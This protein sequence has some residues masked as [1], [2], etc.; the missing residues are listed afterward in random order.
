MQ[1]AILSLIMGVITLVVGL[2][3]ADVVI[4]NVTTAL[5]NTSIGSY[6]GATG[7]GGL[8]P[9]L[10]FVV[11]IAMT[12]GLVSLGG[13]GLAGRGPLAARINV[14]P[15]VAVAVPVTVGVLNPVA[16]PFMLTMVAVGVATWYGVHA[17]SAHQ[18]N[19]ELAQVS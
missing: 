8:I 11:M 12:I 10:Y 13:A 2:V 15:I 18:R 6:S 7:I 19:K 5:T 14:L 9:M 17:F 16:A 4:D 1:R 3:L